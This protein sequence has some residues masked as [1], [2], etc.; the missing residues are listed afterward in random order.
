MVDGA[1]RNAARRKNAN[2]SAVVP[3]IRRPIGARPNAVSCCRLP[4]MGG[5]NLG[6]GRAFRRLWVFSCTV[7][8][9]IGAGGCG[10]EV[11]PAPEG[12]VLL[13]VVDT[14]RADYVGVYGADVSTPN[15]DRLAARGVTFSHAYSHIPITGPSHSTLF[16]SLLPPEHGVHNN[17]QIF[18]P[19][20]P[21]LAEILRD[22]GRQTA[23]IVSLGV[24]NGRFGFDRGF[25]S[26]L[27]D[28]GN[29]WMKDA[30]E[31]NDEVQ[32]VLENGFTSPYFLWVHYSDPHEPYAPP[33]LEYPKVRLVDDDGVVGEFSADGRGGTFELTLQPGTNR[34]RFV[35]TESETGRRYRFTKL[36][37]ESDRAEVQLGDDWTLRERR[38]GPTTFQTSLPAAFEL[39]NP[40][41]RSASVKIQ[42]ACKEL[43]KIPEIRG[44]YALEVE[45]VDR[46]IGR[47]MA[48]LEGRGLLDDTLVIFASD[49]GEGLGD[50]KHV[51][52]ISQLYD[53]LLRVPLVFS[54]PGHLPEGVVIEQRVGLVDVLPTVAELLNLPLPAGTRGR[55]LVPLMLGS[56]SPMRPLIAATYRPEASSDKQ[57]IIMD[58]FKYIHSQ[59]DD[60]EWVEL[61]DL[62]ADPDELENL[63]EV[64]PEELER[65]RAALDVRLQAIATVMVREAE[66][67]EEERAQLR[68]LGYLH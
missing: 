10:T 48:E 42:I 24:L 63:A 14:L 52:H 55:N 46:Q 65:L 62:A 15:I 23:A 1:P 19:E 66:L 50:H 29:D 64:R 57:A 21:I 54:Y 44:R 4:R 59:L 18:E 68:A 61:F 35:S 51:G 41:S 11:A 36:H 13:I 25:D 45:F 40:R 16:S 28:F 17:A 33:H 37:V 26:Y 31:V 27:D 32:A 60:S 34:L 8:M 6:L 58:G 38:T 2:P 39:L 47:L 30:R 67:G 7:A 5:M 43:L 56:A 22:D 9:A 49:H 3:S 12:N 53:S 20:P